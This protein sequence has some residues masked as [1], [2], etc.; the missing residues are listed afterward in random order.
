MNAV[1]V[2]FFVLLYFGFILFVVAVIIP[3]ERWLLIRRGM[4]PSKPYLIEVYDVLQE[5]ATHV[6]RFVRWVLTFY[7]PFGMHDCLDWATDYVPQLGPNHLIHWTA[8]WFLTLLPCTFIAPFW[9]RRSVLFG[10]LLL[11]VMELSGPRPHE[12]GPILLPTAIGVAAVAF[13][14]VGVA[15]AYAI[16]YQADKFFYRKE[17]KQPRT[18]DDPPP[19]FGSPIADVKQLFSRQ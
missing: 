14:L 16:A 3:Y 18:E 5:P 2:V 8:I 7:V 15:G 13:S 6:A 12:T 10:T 1:V 11:A 9:R 17:L 19:H 4:F